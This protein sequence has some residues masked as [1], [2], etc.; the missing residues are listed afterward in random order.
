VTGG[1][2]VLRDARIVDGR[3]AR[4]GPDAR[5]DIHVVDGRIASIAPAGATP[6]RDDRTPAG[7]APTVFDLAGRWVV[8]GLMNAHAHLCLDGGP[9]P[10]ANLRGETRSATVVRSAARLEATL[11]A[12]VT[13]M[14][15]RMSLSKN[16]R[17]SGTS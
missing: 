16:M 2:I 10:E 3:G 15:K 17:R 13:T 8:P 12:G 9:D 1:P 4:D 11:R 5:H 14:R 6:A 7:H